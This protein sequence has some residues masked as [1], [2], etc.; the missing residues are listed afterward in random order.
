MQ[1]GTSSNQAV[2]RLKSV[3]MLGLSSNLTTFVG[4]LLIWI[5]A[6][7]QELVTGF[8]NTLLTVLAFTPVFM[9]DAINHY[10]L[11]RIRLEHLKGWDDI[12]ITPESRV[13]TAHHYQLFRMA[14][15][16]PSYLLAATILSGLGLGSAETDLYIRMAFLA[17]FVLHFGRA[18]WF[19]HRCVAPRLPGYGGR[20]LFWRTLIS[21]SVFIGWFIWF[22]AKLPQ[23]PEKTVTYS[24]GFT[25]ICGIFY[26]FL[27][28]FMHP[29]PTRYSLLRPGKVTRREVFFAVEI[30]DDEQ[31]KAMKNTGAIEAAVTDSN[32]ELNFTKIANIRMPL[33]ELPLFQAWGSIF[34]GSDGKVALLVLDTEV[35]RGV[36]RCLVSFTEDQTFITTDFGA[37]QAKFP[38][39]VVYSN[40][41]RKSSAS[42]MMQ[43]HLQKI[44]GQQVVDIRNSICLKLEHFVKSMIKFLEKDASS[45]QDK[46]SNSGESNESNSEPT[47]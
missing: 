42:A 41:D 14:S 9:A 29:L 15:I 47:S 33:L 20:R 11:G 2:E 40:L 3:F 43:Q 12:Q 36:H 22:S 32:K 7:R 23:L 27:N 38:T 17:A 16:I 13:L 34:V 44:D 18:T 39:S 19:L 37:P 24:A 30:L 4:L 5:I 6:A 31:F 26:F 46:N 21:A 25:F 10:C 45:K 28:A 1:Q 8:F 35:D